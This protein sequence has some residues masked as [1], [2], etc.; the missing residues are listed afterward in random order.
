MPHKLIEKL[1]KH[2]WSLFVLMN[3]TIK[4]QFEKT[5]HSTLLGMRNEVI[6]V[7]A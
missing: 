3:E 7:E 1:N 6:T 2:L 5:T 4:K